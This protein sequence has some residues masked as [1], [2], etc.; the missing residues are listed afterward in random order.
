M[1]YTSFPVKLYKFN[2]LSNIFLLFDNLKFFIS[3]NYV[4]VTSDITLK[5]H[6]V[7][8]FVAVES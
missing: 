2:S 7:T 3:T 1:T 6:I 5:F 4:Y 8:A